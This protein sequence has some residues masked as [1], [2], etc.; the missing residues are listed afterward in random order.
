MLLRLLAVGALLLASTV[1]YAWWSRQQGRVRHVVVAGALTRADLGVTPGARGTVVVFSTPLC[2]KCPG[3]KAML[4]RLLD[5]Y[6]GV[7]QAEIDAA[8]RLDIARRFDIMRT[9]TVLV[10]DANGVAVARMDGA[11]T[12]MQ[13]REAID[14]LPPL[15]GYSI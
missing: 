5:D 15:S 4:S 2:A 1:A 12:P 7:A 6:E 8:E 10:L 14:A 13:A 9:P 3:T 11:P